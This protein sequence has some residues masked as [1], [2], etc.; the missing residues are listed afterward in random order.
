M[1][2]IVIR[3]DASICIGSG[4]VIRCLTLAR[5]LRQYGADIVFICRPQTGDLITKITSEFPVLS[6]PCLTD[7]HPQNSHLDPSYSPDLSLNPLG[8]SQLQDSSDSLELIDQFLDTSPDWI[9]VDHYSLDYQWEESILSGLTDDRETRLLVIDDLANR[10]HQ[11]DC[12][13]DPN[14]FGDS[15][16]TRYVAKVPEACRLLLGPHYAMLS[17][18]Y[19]QFASIVSSRYTLK[20][21][22]VFFGGVDLPNLTSLA[23]L[24]LSRDELLDLE[25]DVVIGFNSPHRITIEQLV[26]QRPNT[27]LHYDLPSLASLTSAADLAIGAGGSTTWERACLGLPSLVITIADNQIALSRHL[28][29]NGFIRLLGHFDEIEDE[30]IYTSLVHL[31]ENFEFNNAQSLTDGFGARR[32]SIFM[33]G[34]DQAPLLREASESDEFVLLRWRNDPVV[35]SN[36]LSTQTVPAEIHKIW[37]KQSLVDPNRIILILIDSSGC[38]LGQIRFDRTSNASSDAIH[39][40]I[41]ISLDRCVRGLG[42]SSSVISLSIAYLQRAWGEEIEIYAE[43]LEFNTVSQHAFSKCGFIRESVSSSSSNGILQLWRW[44]PS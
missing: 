8:C 25:V 21:V 7:T 5:V 16:Y 17:P 37:F 4:H 12:L 27:Y 35:R 14:F 13:I 31:R 3:T 43:I 30:S 42:I 2:S 23:L 26:E 15:T 41:S 24:A 10:Y 29:S 36:S 44:S 22:L 11:A 39:A 18:D 1:T 38:S 6:L 32:V 19:A 20:R 9:I 34:L 28:H 40:F 33:L